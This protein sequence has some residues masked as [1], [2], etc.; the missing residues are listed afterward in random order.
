MTIRRLRPVACGL[1]TLL[2]AA[3][4]SSARAQQAAVPAAAAAP[5]DPATAKSIRQ[6]IELSHVAA[7]MAQ[8][9][10]LMIANQRQAN[11]RIPTEF[12]DAFGKKA[13][14]GIPQLID[15]IVPIYARHF[16][17][18]EI[19]QLVQFYATPLGQRL[20]AEQPTLM[21]ESLEMGRKWGMAIGR[22]V[23]DSLQGAGG[24]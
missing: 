20:L 6:L 23:S 19:D 9:M 24:E 11:P 10:D 21:A 12:W 1:L 3:P 8:G 16:S 13:H 5:V 7:N 22:Q 2:A 18:A 15:S 14:E 4:I 17:Q